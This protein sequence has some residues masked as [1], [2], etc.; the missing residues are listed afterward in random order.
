MTLPIWARTNSIWART[1]SAAPQKCAL[2]AGVVL[3]ACLLTGCTS[4]RQWWCNGFK[5]GPN[6]CRPSAPV[7]DQW[8]DADNPQ[9]KSE[10]TDYS[11]WWT[12]FNDPVLNKLVDTAYEQNLP[13]KIAGLRILEARALR[14]M[15]AGSLFPQKQ[16]M[17]G[18]YSRAKFSDNMYP[19]GM[20]P[21]N[22]EYDDWLTGFDMAWELDIWGKIRRGIES[23][24]ANLDAQIENYDDVL[25]ILQAEVAAAYIQMRTL[26]QR[27]ELARK[28]AE[29]QKETLDII[30]KRFRKGVVSELDVRQA[31]AQ[32]AVTESLIPML[33]EAHRK[34]QNALCLLVGMPPGSLE[35]ELAQPAPIPTPPAEVVVGIP[36]ELLRRRPDVRRAERQAAAQC[37]RIGIAEAEFYPHI[38][39]TGTIS[40]EAEQFSDLFNW[41][42]IG[43][44]IG[45]GFQWNI[46][47]YGR[48]RN[49]V[50]AEEARF[51]QAVLAYQNTVLAAN[52]ETEDAIVAFLREQQRLQSLEQAV[53]EVRRALEIGLHLYEQGVIDY[54]RVLDSVRALVLQQDALAESQGKVATNL[55]AVYKAMGGGWRMRYAPNILEAETGTPF[56]EVPAPAEPVP[57]PADA[58]VLPAPPSMPE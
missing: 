38:A 16:Q 29:L 58:P 26:E 7:A 24:D 21:G 40:V 31:K 3:G 23:A 48:I 42:S 8:I 17:I 41:N 37:A 51:M 44:R 6:Y 2:I 18:A 55:V 20:F 22:R 9:V 35:A 56:E 25:V 36:A 19:F 11:Y 14:G 12:V 5:V 57:V 34:V 32:L 49:N 47:N 52:K 46:L 54:Q 15:A 30:E 10:A 33:E 45:P 28:N 13:L 53:R 39:I 4:T 50:R 27:L 43:G 1:N